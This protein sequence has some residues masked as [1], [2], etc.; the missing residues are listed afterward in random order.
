MLLVRELNEPSEAA[1]LVPLIMASVPTPFFVRFT[2]LAIGQPSAIENTIEF[3]RDAASASEAEVAA[4]VAE[5][6]ALEA[7]VA[8]SAARV[9]A[10]FSL[11]PSGLELSIAQAFAD[12]PLA[13]RSPMACSF[14]E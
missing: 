13:V 1:E 9:F 14:E 3:V 6:E 8:A 12:P 5:P 4:A 7:E 11:L 2:N 10:D